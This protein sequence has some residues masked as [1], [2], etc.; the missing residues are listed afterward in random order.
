MLPA[1]RSASLLPTLAALALLAAAS[2]AQAADDKAIRDAQARFAEGLARVK[3]G[4]YEAARISFAQAYVVLHKSDILWNLALSEEKSGHPLE[5]LAHFKELTATATVDTDRANAQ[6][7]AATLMAQTGHLDI[8]A[9]SGAVLTVDGVQNAGLAP[10]AEPLDVAPGRHVVEAKTA[11]GTKS[12]TV[13]T[14]AGETARV[15][16]TGATSTSTSTSTPTSTSTSTSTPTPTPTPTPTSTPTPTPTSALTPTPEPSSTTK[17]VTTAA[18]GTVAVL[19]IGAG[20]YFGLQSQSDAR[21]AS[22]YRANRADSYCV[23]PANV[24]CVALNDAVHSQNRDATISNVFYVTAGLFGAG[25]ALTWVFWP[26]ARDSAAAWVVPTAGP[27][28]A[29]AVVQGRF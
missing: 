9:P 11:E 12:A 1:L 5:A 15:K 20:A 22:S 23:N 10:L 17:I 21:N 2:P 27:S 29:G 6:K 19:T 26:K 28:G 25:A 14:A 24:D 4:D 7:H 18:L 8:D 16:L 3:S 13:E